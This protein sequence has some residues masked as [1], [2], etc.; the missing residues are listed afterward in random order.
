[1][2]ING[3][4]AVGDDAAWKLEVEKLLAQQANYINVL[5]QKVAELTKRVNKK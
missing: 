3:I 4:K 1:M 5:Q 2:P